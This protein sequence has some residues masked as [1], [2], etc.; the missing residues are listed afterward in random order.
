MKLITIF[1]FKLILL[2][3]AALACGCG[4]KM[5]PIPPDS[6][7]PGEVRNFSVKQDGQALVL[8]WQVPRVN[9]D[10]QPLTDIQGFAILRSKETIFRAAGCPPEL[11][12]LAK[13][14]L[15]FPQAGEVKGEQVSYRDENL[16]PGNRYFYRVVGFDRG[17]HPGLG[18]PIL[19]HIWD[20]LPQPPAKLE[21]QAGDRQVT[22]AWPPVTLL[23]NGKT[24]PGVATYNV[25]REA[26]GGGFSLINT[27]PVT[28]TNFQDITAVNEVMYRYLVRTV[29]QVGSG[30]LESLDSPLQTAKPLDLTPPAPVLNLVAVST[31]KGIELRWDAGREPDLAGYRVYRRSL[32][33]P[34]FRLLTPQLDNKPYYVDQETAKGVT[35]YYY[36]VA[37]DNAPRANPSLPSETVE[38]TR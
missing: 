5:A 35:Y 6:L 25:Y 3:V 18:S 22:L 38:I 2:L 12:P 37:V 15:A 10:N 8:R 16:E 21:A 30:S 27:S 34:Q 31:D 14:D 26:K 24:L 11:T 28:A 19:S 20:I 7:V 23:A 4:K 13:I 33:E 29:R 36:V 1:R 32:A 9:V 17:D